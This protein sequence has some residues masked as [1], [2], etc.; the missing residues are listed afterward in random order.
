MIETCR[1]KNV[2]TFIQTTLNSAKGFY[3]IHCLQKLQKVQEKIQP[4]RKAGKRIKT[5]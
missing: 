4:I 1:L 2:V 5:G 3:G